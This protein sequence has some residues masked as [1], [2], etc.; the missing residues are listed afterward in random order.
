VLLDEQTLRILVGLVVVASALALLAGQQR[1]TRHEKLALFPVGLA[2]GV[3]NGSTGMGGPPVIL[4][5]ANQGVEKQSF[6][7]NIIL[8]FTLLSVMTA[9]STGLEGLVT[10]E[11]VTYWVALLP[12]AVLG[13]LIGMRLARR[14]N[15][16][17]FRQITLV[18]LILMGASSIASGL[19]LFA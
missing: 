1:P 13:A 19:G 16:Q 14:V 3:L 8:Y 6:R 15:Q 17:Q 18:V 7:A 5:L 2:S 4:F 12:A 11:V 9:T 10:R